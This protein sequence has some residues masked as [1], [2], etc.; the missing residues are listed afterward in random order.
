MFDN[1]DKLPGTAAL[2]Q[3]HIKLRGDVLSRSRP[4]WKCCVIITYTY[5]LPYSPPLPSSVTILLDGTPHDTTVMPS[6]SA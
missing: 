5:K 6:S 2:V 4:A 1:V 3:L